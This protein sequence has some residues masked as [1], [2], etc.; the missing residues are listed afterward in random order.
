MHA[1]VH[2]STLSFTLSHT[3]VHVHKHTHTHTPTSESWQVLGPPQV[4]PLS[5]WSSFPSSANTQS[6][7]CSWLQQAKRLMH[8]TWSLQSTHSVNGMILNSE[9]T[10]TSHQLGDRH[11]SRNNDI[12]CNS[13][14][15]ATTGQSSKLVL[16]L[17]QQVPSLYSLSHS[18]L[19]QA[20]PLTNTTWPLQIQSMHFVSGMIVT[21]PI[22][23][24]RQVTSPTERIITLHTTA[25]HLQQQDKAVS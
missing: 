2:I 21:K 13:K 7:S 19:Q 8:T 12:T 11:K 24:I 22:N 17:H 6:L 14:A 18:W 15:P 1:C 25:K 23:Y 16:S 4:F 20:E 3:H 9:K 5:K 10:D